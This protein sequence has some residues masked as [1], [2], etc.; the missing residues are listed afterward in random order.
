MWA[1]FPQK[2]KVTSF[3]LYGPQKIE[4]ATSFLLLSLQKIEM[5]ASF[6]LPPP[7]PP[8]KMKRLHRSRHFT[9]KI[10]IVKTFSLHI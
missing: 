6:W 10:E 8:K 5:V 3:T 9:P 4:T 2:V 7:P 1:S